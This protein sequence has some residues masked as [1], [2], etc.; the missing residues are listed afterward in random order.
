MSSIGCE[1]LG[2][3]GPQSLANLLPPRHE[4]ARGERWP[5]GLRRTLGKRVCGKPYRGFESHSLRHF[6]CASCAIRGRNRLKSQYKQQPLDV[7]PYGRSADFGDLGLETACVSEASDCAD[8]VRR[9]KAAILAVC[10]CG[11]ADGSNLCRT[12]DSVR[13][14]A[15]LKVGFSA[16]ANQ[17][18]HSARPAPLLCEASGPRQAELKR[19]HR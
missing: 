5:S 19:R 1:K 13:D 3:P 11:L 12:W 8:L 9:S 14:H 4:R 6:S 18:Q 2:G 17:N 15:I 7:G 10:S 16:R